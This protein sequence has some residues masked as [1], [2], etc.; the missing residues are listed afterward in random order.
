MPTL[1]LLLRPAERPLADAEAT[2]TVDVIHRREHADFLMRVIDTP[3]AMRHRRIA[4]LRN[5]IASDRYESADRLDRALDALTD[6][7]A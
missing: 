2:E 1:P 5:E 6:D 4:E 7:L 3:V